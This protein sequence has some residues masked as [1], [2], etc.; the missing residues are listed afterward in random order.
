MRRWNIVFSPDH[1]GAPRAGDLCAFFRTASL[2]F[3]FGFAAGSV[4]L[5]LNTRSAAAK[6]TSFTALFAAA[7]FAR[8]RG[9]VPD[10][11]FRR[12]GYAYAFILCLSTVIG[13]AMYL[14]N[15]LYGL[16]YGSLPELLAN[17]LFL[18]GGTAVAGRL[19]GRMMRAYASPRSCG[20]GSGE[21]PF[22]FLRF[23]LYAVVL[24]AAWMPVF[25]AYYPG[26]YSY[27]CGQQMS[28]FITDSISRFQSAL[29]TALWGLCFRAA[30]AVGREPV[31]VYVLCQMLFCALAGA[32]AAVSLG[33]L[34]APRG[35]RIALI[36]FWA[37]FPLSALFAV[38]FVKDTLFTACFILALVEAL[39]CAREPFRLGHAALYVLFALLACLLRNNAVYAMLPA[40]IP[41][42]ALLFRSRR[43]VSAAVLFVPTV[44]YFLVN[45]PV[46]DHLGVL[47]GDPR[48]VLSVPVQQIARAASA[49]EPVS[50]VGEAIRA[51]FGGEDVSAAYNPRFADP[52][53]NAFNSALFCSPGGK[54]GFLSLWGFLL[55]EQP[56]EYLDAAL[57]LNLPLWYPC[58]GPVDP[59]SMRRYAET[60]TEYDEDDKYT[61]ERR[62]KLP[63]LLSVY[64]RI[65][66]ASAADRIPVL[67]LPF[68]ISLP[69]WVHLFV[70]FSV[71]SGRRPFAALI[72][73][74]ALLLWATY[75]L[76]PV[77]NLRYVFPLI[78]T[79]P[80]LAA[81]PWLPAVTARRFPP[82]EPRTMSGRTD[83]TVPAFRTSVLPG[84]E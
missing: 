3:A 80:L 25:L 14:T 77:S 29:H 21:T 27:D 31:T 10:A 7:L 68:S 49:G 65:A 28:E 18:I 36:A 41:I 13:K 22:S 20:N 51:Y 45:G 50:E 39:W 64:E 24:F 37:V 82:G 52:V 58:A 53:K 2:C 35:V 9:P 43:A 79:Y 74:Y 84:E 72:P 11:R 61:P 32:Y 75:L 66:D 26:I 59:F 71:V 5:F 54:E 42:A 55:R 30:R 12:S 33:C 83:P 47:P 8:G 57:T 19:F 78:Q 16:L 81:L 48:E 63:A 44:L 69:V 56:R 1:R 67:R 17:V 34:G 4:L 76:G 73:L 70:L 62:S 40:A 15:S 23:A 38:T 6:A 46:Y 60:S